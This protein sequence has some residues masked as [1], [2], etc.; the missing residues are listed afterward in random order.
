MGKVRFS[1]LINISSLKKMA[2]NIYAVAE[3]PIG[4]IDADDTINIAVGWQ[5]IC[6]KFHRIHPDACKRCLISD[7]Y[8]SEHIRDGGYISYKC[9]NN[10]WDIALPIVILGE[11]MATIFL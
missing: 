10:M 3:I 8:I 5:D 6:T 7:H 1:E 11:H 9:L 4:I 2:E